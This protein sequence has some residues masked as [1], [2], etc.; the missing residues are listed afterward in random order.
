L[1]KIERHYSNWLKTIEPN[2]GGGAPANLQ[3]AARRELER[4][5]GGK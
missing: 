2:T 4:R 3:D 5:L 1:E